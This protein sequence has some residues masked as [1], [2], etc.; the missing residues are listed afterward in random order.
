MDIEAND[1]CVV[2][3]ENTFESC[4]LQTGVHLSLFIC[5]FLGNNWRYWR[6]HFSGEVT[7]ECVFN[8]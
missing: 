5:Y 6:R 8:F 2:S 4:V 1:E 7:A 3:K